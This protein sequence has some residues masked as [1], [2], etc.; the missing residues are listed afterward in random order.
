VLL[1]LIVQEILSASRGMEMKKYQVVEMEVLLV[2]TI[3]TM[4]A[5]LLTRVLIVQLHLSKVM[6]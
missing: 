6:A 5:L 4:M 3:A 1:M 2:G